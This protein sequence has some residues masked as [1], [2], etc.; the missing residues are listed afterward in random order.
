MHQT[1]SP[2]SNIIFRNNNLA[3]PVRLLAFLL[4]SLVSKSRLDLANTSVGSDTAGNTASRHSTSNILALEVNQESGIDGAEAARATERIDLAHTAQR[5]RADLVGGGIGA[6]EDLAD[7]LEERCDDVLE[8]VALGQDVGVAGAA[9]ERV[10][11]VGVPVVVHGVQQRVAADLGRTSRCVVHVVALERHEVRAS[12]EVQ[13][14]V[15]VAV[16]G[17][18]PGGGAVDLGVGDCNAAGGAVTED[19]VLAADERGVD[20]VDPGQVC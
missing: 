15:V 13:C 6:S 11:A 7:A 10:P 20:V 4:P 2:Q 5:R 12:R 14:P 16:A 3:T 18:G 19:D 17:G 8:D 9:V 1:P